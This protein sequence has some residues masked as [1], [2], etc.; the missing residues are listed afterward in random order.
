MKYSKNSNYKKNPMNLVNKNPM[1]LVNKR[2][3]GNREQLG[4]KEILEQLEE[5]RYTEAAA[6]C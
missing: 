3:G 5:L 1:N 6:T 4:S 2:N